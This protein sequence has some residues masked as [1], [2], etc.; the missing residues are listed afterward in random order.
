MFDVKFVEKVKK[1][2]NYYE[3]LYKDHE[4]FFKGSKTNERYVLAIGIDIMLQ[5][6]EQTKKGL[7]DEEKK[8][9]YIKEL[10]ELKKYEKTN[11][12]VL[13]IKMIQDDIKKIYEL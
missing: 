6:I 3:M 9:K 10:D 11:Y 4:E 2:L 13:T 5:C 8:D 12:H 1:D 7:A